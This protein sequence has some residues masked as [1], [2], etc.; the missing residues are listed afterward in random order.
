MKILIID[1]DEHAASELERLIG[2]AYPDAEILD[3][4]TTVEDS[5]RW[6][7]SRPVP[8]LIFLDVQLDDGISFD[9]FQEVNTVVPLV[10]TTHNPSWAV[11]A[12]KLNTIGYLFKPLDKNGIISI[13]YKNKLL[14]QYYALKEGLADGDP[15]NKNAPGTAAHKKIRNRFVVHLGDKIKFVIAA[16]IA[17]FKAEGNLVY[18]MTIHNDKSIIDESLEEIYELLDLGLFFRINRTY[19]CHIQAL[20]DIRRYFNSRLKIFLVPDPGN[21][22]EIFVSR[23]RVHDFLAWLGS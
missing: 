3:T 21:D 18:M 16:E 17:W 10:F 2:L 13:L 6:L 1:N 4:L 11:K 14:S 15:L 20:K 23:H 9:I 12:Y 19:I 8:D 5:V 22:D 7:I